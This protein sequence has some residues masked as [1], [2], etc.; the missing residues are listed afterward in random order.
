MD[1]NEFF[2]ENKIFTT[3]KARI[4]G[5]SKSDLKSDK[6]VVCLGTF[7]MRIIN[8]EGTTPNTRMES[9]WCRDGELALLIKKSKKINKDNKV[10]VKELVTKIE[11]IIRDKL[12][13]NMETDNDG[14]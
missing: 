9:V 10:E 4:Q 13:Y 14:N 12:G 1:N 3:T 7:P 6:E 5:L 11:G 2:E 8:K